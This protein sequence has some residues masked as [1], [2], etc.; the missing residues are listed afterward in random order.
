[1]RVGV[2]F[3]A[4]AGVDIWALGRDERRGGDVFG[5]GAV[6]YARR[7]G[8]FEGCGMCLELCGETLRGDNVD[9]LVV[10]SLLDKPERLA[11]ADLV[12]EVF[13]GVPT[14]LVLGLLNAGIFVSG[15]IGVTGESMELGEGFDLVSW[16]IS[17]G[18]ARVAGCLCLLGEVDT[19]TFD[20]LLRCRSV[21]RSVFK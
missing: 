1:M 11:D 18:N 5:G 20:L 13:E 14:G 16:R 15:D 19:S 4:A 3:G 21:V 10:V 2:P 17:V 6:T 8:D 7:V 12:D 9:L